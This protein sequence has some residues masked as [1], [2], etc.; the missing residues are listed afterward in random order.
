MRGWALSSSFVP[1][2]YLDDLLD[3]GH[4]GVV[5]VHVGNGEVVPVLCGEEVCGCVGGWV[6]VSGWERELLP[7]ARTYP[8]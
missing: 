6:D 4:G 5:V 7:L 1:P 8:K 3:G 2:T